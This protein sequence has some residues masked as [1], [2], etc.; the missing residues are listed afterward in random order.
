[1]SEVA[2]PFPGTNGKTIL[3]TGASGFIASHVVRAFLIAG[4]HVRGTVRSEAAATRVIRS[5]VE[6]ADRISF[7]MVPDLAAAGAFDKAV[8][9]VDGVNMPLPPR[10]SS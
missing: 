2:S 7:S 10:K 9:G 1:M 5:H 4:Y 6:Y 3:I 8:E